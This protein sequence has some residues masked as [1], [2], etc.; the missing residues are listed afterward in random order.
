M[1][2]STGAEE[3]VDSPFTKEF[4]KGD[5]MLWETKNGDRFEGELK[6]LDV[7]Y[8]VATGVREVKEEGLECESML[9]YWMDCIFVCKP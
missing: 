2:P 9:M 3:E 8:F 1:I 6:Y 5:R 7:E 4:E